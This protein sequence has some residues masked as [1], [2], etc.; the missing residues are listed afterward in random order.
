[1]RTEVGNQDTTGSGT[2]ARLVFG[3][4]AALAEFEQELIRERTQAGLQAAM[5]HRDT[6]VSEL[7]IQLGIKPVTLYRYVGPQGQLRERG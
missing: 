4:F 2:D 6:S 5:A 3:I 7:G 1:M